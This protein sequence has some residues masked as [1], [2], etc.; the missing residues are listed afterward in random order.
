MTTTRESD[1]TVPSV[2]ST[3]RPADRLRPPVQLEPM[4]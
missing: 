2:P 4:L 3:P 1:V